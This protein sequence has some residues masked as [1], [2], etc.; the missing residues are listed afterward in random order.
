MS[1]IA[2]GLAPFEVR[3]SDSPEMPVVADRAMFQADLD[4]LRVREKR[5]ESD[6]RDTL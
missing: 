5:E 6:V 3:I 1:E 2:N 4:A